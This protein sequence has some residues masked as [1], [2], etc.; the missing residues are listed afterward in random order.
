M[1]ILNSKTLACVAA[2]ALLTISRAQNPDNTQQGPQD[3]GANQN[4]VNQNQGGGSTPNVII[5]PVPMDTGAMYSNMDMGGVP[6]VDANG[7]P[8]QQQ[9]APQ[10]QQGQ[11]ANPNYNNNNFN[12]NRF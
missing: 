4:G 11:P 3:N 9:V 5:V 7:Q 6:P 12:N 8:L 2:S 1:K 10:I